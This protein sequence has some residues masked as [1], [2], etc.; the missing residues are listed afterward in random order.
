MELKGSIAMEIQ[1]DNV[2]ETGS[3]N[4]GRSGGS[5]AAPDQQLASS[6]NAVVARI[7]AA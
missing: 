5:Q 2:G 7:A 4:S 3:S 1:S 6:N